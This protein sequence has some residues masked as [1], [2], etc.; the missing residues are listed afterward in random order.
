MNRDEINTVVIGGGQAGLAI[1]YHL[2]QR[3]L[4]FVILDENQRIGD[5]WRNR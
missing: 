4:P 1:G 5:V 3:G 2:R